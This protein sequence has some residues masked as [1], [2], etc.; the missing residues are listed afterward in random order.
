[1]VPHVLEDLLHL[2]GS[3]RV[4]LGVGVCVDN[5]SGGRRLEEPVRKFSQTGQ[6]PGRTESE[7]ECEN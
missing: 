4:R 6:D 3:G 7:K 2:L 5:P 1:M